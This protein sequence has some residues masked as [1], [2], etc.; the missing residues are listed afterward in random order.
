MASRAGV[1]DGGARSARDVGC[2]ARGALGDERGVGTTH[3]RA[4][5]VTVPSGRHAGRGGRAE[6]PISMK[7]SMFMLYQGRMFSP[8]ISSGPDTASNTALLQLIIQHRA[9]RQP[10]IDGPR[11]ASDAVNRITDPPPPTGVL[12]GPVSTRGVTRYRGGRPRVCASHGVS[13]RDW[14]VCVLPRWQIN[15]TVTTAATPRPSPRRPGRP[16]SDLAHECAATC[17]RTRAVVC[18]TCMREVCV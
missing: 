2:R 16:L 11:G 10:T 7:K 13:P 8:L 18:A 1:D 17:A 5:T 3:S 6:R 14:W 15:V 4:A 9:A 12:A